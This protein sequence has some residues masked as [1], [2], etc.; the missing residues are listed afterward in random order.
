MKRLSAKKKKLERRLFKPHTEEKRRGDQLLLEKEFDPGNCG[1]EVKSV[2]I[3][4][5]I[6]F[7]HAR[8]H[9]S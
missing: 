9:T 1:N 5:A 4:T 2:D 8:A 6:L 3:Q 7:A